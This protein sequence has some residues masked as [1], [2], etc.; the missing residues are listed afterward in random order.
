[1]EERIRR[2]ARD[3]DLDHRPR[4]NEVVVGG[5]FVDRRTGVELKIARERDREHEHDARKA[6]ARAHALFSEHQAREH[7]HQHKALKNDDHGRGNFECV[8]AHDAARRADE[9][10][11]GGEHGV[12]AQLHLVVARER[13]REKRQR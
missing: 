4:G 3:V 12:A 2:A 7:E 10:Q 8:V 11:V 9:P 13:E 1:M 6:G 5:L